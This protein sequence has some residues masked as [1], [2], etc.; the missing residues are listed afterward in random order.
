[1]NPPAALLDTGPLVALLSRGDADHSR[2]VQLFADNAPPF[3]RLRLKRAA[4]LT[5]SCSLI[6]V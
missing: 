1:M 3:R 4:R 6:A 2:A 5:S